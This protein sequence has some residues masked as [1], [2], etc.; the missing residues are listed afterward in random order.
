MF[1]LFYSVLNI[2]HIYTLFFNSIIVYSKYYLLLIN[3]FNYFSFVIY[4]IFSHLLLFIIKYLLYFILLL[5]FNN[6]EE[7]KYNI[8][9]EI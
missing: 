4:F 6:I 9:F 5:K 2:L 3:L 7:V 1:Y 8:Y